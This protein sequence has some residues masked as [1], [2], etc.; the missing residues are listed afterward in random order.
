MMMEGLND[1][2]REAVTQPLEHVLVLAG[3]GSGKTRVLTTRMAWLVQSGQ[4]APRELL[5]V[6]FTNKAAREMLARLSALLPIDVR[7][8]WVGTFHGLCNRL[9]RAHHREAG[10]PQAFQILDAADQL[11]AI[12]RLLKAQGADTDRF[13]ARDVQRMINAAKED[14]LRPADLDVRDSHGRRL[15]GLYQAYQ[16][17]CEREGVVDFAELL[18]R[19][20]ELL[21]QD[22][23]LRTHY[24][25]RFRQIL[26]DEFQ[27]TNRL[28][29]RWLMLLAEGGAP[30]FAVGDDDQSIYAFRGAQVG[31]MADFET[32]HA[33]GR[34]I[35]L[36]QNYRSHGHILDAANALIGHNRG[37]LGKKLW[38]AQGA[39]EP[40]RVVEQVSDAL[41]AQWLAD[42]IRAL[43]RDGFPAQ[44]I[45]IL[46]RSNAQ[47]RPIEHALFSARVPYRVYGGQRFFERQE[48]KHVLAYLRLLNQ[49][50]DDTSWM[51]VVNFPTR[52]IGSRTQE[53]LLDMA[54]QHGLSL[55]GAVAFVP[56]KAGAALAR[57]ASLIRELALAG[58]T[59]DLP[60]LIGHVVQASGLEA[61]Y[62]AEREGQERLDNLQEL[63]NAAA[64]FVAEADLQG[65]AAGRVPEG[66]APMSPLAAFLSHAA[67]EAGD[68][69]AQAGQDA[70]QLMTIHAA[71]GL[72]F[73]AVFITGLEEGLF[74]HENSL[75][76]ADGLEEERRLMYVAM[77][78]ARKRL[79]LTLAQSRLLHGQTR[80]GLRSRFLDEIPEGHL[81]WLTPRETARESAPWRG[82]FRRGLGAWQGGE[83]QPDR[84]PEP[85]RPT[86]VSAP[87]GLA[88]GVTVGEQTYNIG[89]RVQH[90]RFGEGTV[91]SLSGNGDDALARIEFA[92]T[93]TKTL[94]LGVARLAVLD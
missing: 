30:V 2:Q 72:E 54:R 60:E 43:L 65:L 38:T 9:L 45:A 31:N 17:Q 70:V 59:L 5:A 32:R 92:D 29:Y 4:L 25:Q 82:A 73:D 62:R 6:T 87:R 67:L 88:T 13:P 20:T 56:G 28:Q 26:V 37:R 93:G 90:D 33:H 78:R 1:A 74:P 50:D 83:Q 12:K 18:L 63:V 76:E 40:L 22:A 86:R 34:V 49:P 69:Q 23:A 75:L 42:E 48:V 11:S 84:L 94:A 44:D 58:Q 85:R 16:D 89:M 61:H 66:D 35:R 8:M 81:K 24:Q 77:T 14:G 36:E 51:R 53:Q 3:A 41:E 71:K 46:Y 64:A 27:D 39:G 80:Y 91:I 21:Q 52:G 47:S 79:T 55:A 15:A 68:N 19:A 10:L 7:G 57:F